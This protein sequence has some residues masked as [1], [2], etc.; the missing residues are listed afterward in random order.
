MISMMYA[1]PIDKSENARVLQIFITEIRC[2]PV[3]QDHSGTPLRGARVS[4]AD[5]FLPFLPL[6][7]LLERRSLV[8]LVFFVFLGVFL[9]FLVVFL[10]AFL[11]VFFLVVFFT[12]FLVFL[13]TF[14]VTFLVAFLATFLL[15]TFF[16]V[17][18]ALVA[19]LVV[20]DLDL[21]DLP[22]VA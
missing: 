12:A 18:L 22:L 20:L 13:V 11:A 14:L 21:V 5:H 17:F 15:V 6:V 9:A 2:C 19:F 16:L 8:F 4:W 10:V 3:R 1:K 7:F